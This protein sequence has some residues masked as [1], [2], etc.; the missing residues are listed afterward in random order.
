M[1]LL[2]RFTGAAW[3][4][5]LTAGC[6][7]NLT[8]QPER[9][10][11]SSEQPVALE[12]VPNL[13]GQIDASELGAAIGVPVNFLVNPAGTEI[14]VD[15]EGARDQAGVRVWDWTY[16]DSDD[17]LLT[18]EAEDIA[19]K[20]YAGSFPG[21]EFV[22]D[23]DATG[24]DESILST[25]ES[26]L[27]LHGFAS[28]AENPESGQTLFVYQEPVVVYPFPVEPGASWVSTGVVED[29]TLRGLPYAGRDVYEGSV[30]D[31]GEIWLPDIRFE[32]AHRVTTSV[33]IQPAVG[34]SARRVQV[35]FLFECFGE[36]A[37]AVSRN[38]ETD[39]DFNIATQVRRLGF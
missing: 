3:V 19:S 2:H 7:D 26:G 8:P 23:L 38:G 20:W 37:R 33:T 12:C 35:S 5:L 9:E 39:R 6:S 25:D 32:Q 36:V 1:T 18:V 4:V 31:S 13:D 17:Q 16:D 34:E 28:A 21:G 15:L 29:A 10:P 14:E 24:R 22:S 30:G 27:L 11:F